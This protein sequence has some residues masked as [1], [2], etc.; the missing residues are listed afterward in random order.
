MN[1]K[2]GKPSGSSGSC[3]PKAL[4]PRSLYQGRGRCELGSPRTQYKKRRQEV[5]QSQALVLV[6]V[7]VTWKGPHPTPPSEGPQTSGMVAGQPVNLEDEVILEEE[8]ADDGE[9]VDENEGQQGGQ[10]D[11]A[12]VAG[13]ALDDVEQG[14]L[15]V[16]EV[17]EL[18]GRDEALRT[19]GCPWFPKASSSGLHLGRHSPTRGPDM[20]AS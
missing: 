2:V 5:K 18:Q 3:R 17:K 4:P 8:E 9:E 13:H 7:S 14:L 6:L 12:A 11:G 19:W 1:D 20:E 10:Q 16:N 15:T